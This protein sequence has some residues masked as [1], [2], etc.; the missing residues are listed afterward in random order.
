[1]HT[2]YLRTPDKVCFRLKKKKNP[3]D[4]FN[5]SFSFPISLSS[6]KKIKP[7]IKM[8]DYIKLNLIIQVKPKA[9]EIVRKKKRL[10]KS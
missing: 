10:V 5:H 3:A 8:S 4:L 9:H 1:M 2:H 7:I 6:K